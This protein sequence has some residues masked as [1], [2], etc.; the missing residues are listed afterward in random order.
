MIQGVMTTPALAANVEALRQLSDSL[1]IQLKSGPELLQGL[2]ERQRK[3]VLATHVRELDLLYDGGLRRGTFVELHGEESSGCFA[4]ALAALGAATQAGESAALIDLPAHLDP[5]GTEAAG[6]DLRRLLWLRPPDLKTA[7]VSA[8]MT[9][10]TGFALVVLNLGNVKVTSRH[11]PPASWL[12][13]AR[14]AAEQKGI[15]MVVGRDAL[16]SVAP[17]VIIAAERRQIRWTGSG[18]H[19]LLAGITAQISV[20]HRKGVRRALSGTLTF[21]SREG[22]G[23]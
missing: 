18:P 9:L 6:V 20:K 13:L 1:G 7:L 2:A 8:E 22:I 3:P 19:P 10:S 16:E 4:I 12:R 17:D 5:Q 11:A 23:R 15:F 14:A 21:A